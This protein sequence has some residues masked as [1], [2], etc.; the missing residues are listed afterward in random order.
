[1]Y[2]A[3]VS[4]FMY[5]FAVANDWCVRACGRSEQSRIESNTQTHACSRTKNFVCLQYFT[6]HALIKCSIGEVD[7]T[8]SPW[9]QS[10]K[11]IKTQQQKYN[12]R[13]IRESC[14]ITTETQ[15]MLPD[16]MRLSFFI[17]SHKE[18]WFYFLT[19]YWIGIRSI[20]FS[21]YTFFA[22]F[23]KKNNDYNSKNV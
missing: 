1:M 23:L 18:N 11:M 15:L 10:I 16:M 22:N 9:V 8:T 21:F 20:V 7:E 5:S 4:V 19:V 12:A 6:Q 13:W 3:R 17:D 14:S 2:T